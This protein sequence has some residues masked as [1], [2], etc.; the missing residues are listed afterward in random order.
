LS[1]K[2]RGTLTL[3]K[4]Q[5]SLILIFTSLFLWAQ[6]DEFDEWDS[7]KPKYL[8]AW[9]ETE[10]PEKEPF[11]FKNRMVELSIANVSLNTTFPD[12]IFKNPYYLL[13]NIKDTIEDANF[14]WQDNVV[15][16]IDNL[17]D[18]FKFFTDI[19][20]KPLSLNFNW[21]DKWG[22]GFDIGHTYVT[23]NVLLSKNMTSLRHTKKDT[24]GMGAAIYTDVGIPVFFRVNDLKIKFRPAVYLPIVYTE[25]GI[26]Y[27]YKTIISEDDGSE[28]IHVETAFDM[29][30]YTIVS[31]KGS[32][33]SVWQDFQDNIWNIL[34]GNTGYDFGLNLEYPWMDDVDI[35]V[36]I[37]NIPVPYASARLNHYM[38]LN[39]EAYLDTSNIVLSDILDGED[40][41]EDVFNLPDD[42][43]D[44]VKHNYN[45][46]GKKI[47][48]PFAML[49]YFRY[50]PFDSEIFML[51]PSL[52]FSINHL[53][54]KPTAIE[55][56]LSACLDFANMFITTFG[57]NYNDRK[58]KN[59]IDFVF[60]FRAIE[61]DIGL[62][63]QSFSFKNS[64][65]AAGLGV[66]AG[67]KLGW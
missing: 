18:N 63:M 10:E 16:D 20:I 8:E 46:N 42:I 64:W 61:L 60:N 11:R 7:R 24:F 56:G 39:G 50:R 4:I 30:V 35:G 59:S 6:D 36:D 49:F 57:I 17:F 53:Y 14:V 66:N 23:G 26:T 34:K 58:W 65:Q 48:R 51:I 38:Q 31:L 27:S 32:V 55:G 12:N 2:N 9:E 67:V 3:K 15:I 25:P 1:R 47:Y 40:I 43:N 22:F 13:F 19:Y 37:V 28:R 5:V 54:L 29:R 41:P 33:D 52:G 21:K 44:M 45:S 62:S